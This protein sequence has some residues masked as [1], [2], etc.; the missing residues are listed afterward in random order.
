VE[1][2]LGPVARVARG[3][4][5]VQAMS[6]KGNDM[7][8]T[9]RSPKEVLEGSFQNTGWDEKT[10]EELG[11]GAKLTH[12]SVTQDFTG[13]VKGEGS[14]QWLMSYRPDGTAHFVGLQRVRGSVDHRKGVFVIETIGEFDGQTASWNAT[15]VPG[16][17]ADDLEGI[18][19][20]GTFEAPLGSTAQ[21][22]MSV[23]FS[24]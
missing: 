5:I 21:F 8:E 24:R 6:V 18:A 1:T 22:T 11:D 15:I 10:I 14:A 16:S 23:S 20:S 7:T 3:V 17:G 2:R 4:R 19:G 13:G 9:T 12:A